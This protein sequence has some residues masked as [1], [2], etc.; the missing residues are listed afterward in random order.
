M[1]CGWC[2]ERRREKGKKGKSNCCTS[3]AD[4]DHRSADVHAGQVSSDTGQIRS[5]TCHI[6]DCITAVRGGLLHHG[7]RMLCASC[8]IRPAS[9]KYK[10]L[11]CVHGEG[12]MYLDLLSEVL[13]PPVDAAAQGPPHAARSDVW[14]Q[15]TWT[16]HA[17]LRCTKVS[18][19][20][21]AI[22]VHRTAWRSA[23][24]LS[25]K[26]RLVITEAKTQGQSAHA[27]MGVAVWR[28][29]AEER[30]P[31]H[32]HTNVRPTLR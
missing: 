21:A 12:L 20:T 5:L 8:T 13:V 29:S 15:G 3:I 10:N 18:N 23:T 17:T 16:M 6:L 11:A 28:R 9:G 30:T 4:W 31:L 7:Q 25:A 26:L 27:K 2:E 24:H 32:M 19:A 1:C 14:R 22:Q